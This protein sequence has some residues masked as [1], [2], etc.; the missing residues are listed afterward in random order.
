MERFKQVIKLSGAKVR[1]LV[2]HKDYAT[3]AAVRR[4]LNNAGKRL[5]LDRR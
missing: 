4:H 2:A 1:A 3:I 5:A